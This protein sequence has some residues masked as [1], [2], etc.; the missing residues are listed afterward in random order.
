[1][2]SARI[3]AGSGPLSALVREQ[4]DLTGQLVA[5]DK[6]LVGV[7]SSPPSAR[8]PDGEA[9]LRSRIEA[10]R[11]RLGDLSS[12]LS[13]RF[14]EYLALASPQPVSIADVRRA[15]R[16][17]E[18]LYTVAF[19]RHDGFLWLVTPETERW[20][21]ID[22][23]R[24]QIEEDVAV[25][26]CGLDATGWDA[27]GSCPELTGQTFTEG[28][29]A[30]GRQ[31][32]FDLAR[33]HALYQTLFSP[34]EDLIKDSQLIVVPTGPLTQLPFHVLVAGDAPSQDGPDVYRRADWLARHAAIT[35]LPAISSLPALRRQAGGSAAPEAY[36]GFGDP[37][38]EGP[39]GRYAGLAQ[40]A[41]AAQSCNMQD[42][43]RAIRTAGLSDRMGHVITAGGL[44]DVAF[45]RSQEPLPETTDE[46]CTVAGSVKA[47]AAAVWL[48]KNA[49]ETSIK[50]MNEKHA[51][52][53]YR[54][55]HFATHAALAGEAVG[56]AE[57]GLLLTP[58][59][60]PPRTMTVI[61]P[62]ARSVRSSSM[63]ISSFS[64]PA[65]RRRAERATVTRLPGWRGPSFMPV[66]A[67][68]WCRIGRCTPA[69]PSS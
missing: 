33:A 11:R 44:A 30:A 54:M 1:M 39:D 36:L 63:R 7:M 67:R 32:P 26:R 18:A 68:S 15:L 61:C 21:R 28:D 13:A 20:V 46:V 9:D 17:K 8:S 50:R 53:R 64:R 27:G 16:P 24:N 42:R 59:L 25:L 49:T 22:R 58:P 52:A 69:Q 29:I 4:Q 2:M 41:R 65:T 60:R 47:G 55:L 3:A 62:Q 31:L 14:P 10:V 56:I 35:V 48:G 6:S 38:L 43:I 40:L 57:P 51:L 23:T 19:T 66:H 45:L 5:L 37:L 12:E 34:V